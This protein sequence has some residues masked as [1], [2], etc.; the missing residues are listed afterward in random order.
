MSSNYHLAQVNI[1][2]ARAPLDQ[3]L[4]KGFVDQLDAINR[5]AEASPGFIWRLQTDEGD[6]TSIRAF[7]DPLIIVNLS[8]WTSVEAL[9]EYVYG[10]EH[11]AVLRNK[12]DWM[13]KLPT[14][15]LALWWLPAGELPDVWMAR[16]KLELLQAQGACDEVFT[17]ARPYSMPGRVAVPS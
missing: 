3:P 6:A 12:R 5:L 2:K 9:R 17:F 7:D 4:M 16:R 13:E 15:S 1:A 14:P 11:L 10:G 8:L